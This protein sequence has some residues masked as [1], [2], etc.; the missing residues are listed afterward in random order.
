MHSEKSKNIGIRLIAML[1]DYVIITFGVAIVGIIFIGVGVIIF[2]NLNLPSSV[3]LLFTV[4]SIIFMICLCS[5]YLNKDAI[6]GKSLAKRIFGLIIVNDKTG[7]IAKPIETCLRN[8]TLL[9]WPIEVIFI[10]I[11]PQRRIGDYIAGTKVIDDNKSLNTKISKRQI[12]IS[13]L[14]GMLLIITIGILQF[15]IFNFDVINKILKA[16]L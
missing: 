8:V 3:D 12:I 9:F 11:S 14:L 2:D 6:K 13:M 7:D 16:S 10:I 5:I 1:L 4:L 15:A